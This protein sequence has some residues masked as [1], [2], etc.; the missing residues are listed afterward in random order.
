M[1]WELVQGVWTYNLYVRRIE[2]LL[3]KRETLLVRQKLLSVHLMAT[4]VVVLLGHYVRHGPQENH[5][6]DKTDYLIK[7]GIC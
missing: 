2:E 3:N 1:L 6:M 5:V 7:A 4:S